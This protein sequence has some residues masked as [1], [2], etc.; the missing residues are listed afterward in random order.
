MKE[1]LVIVPTRERPN[2]I[3]ELIEAYADTTSGNSELLLCLDDDDSGN[4]MIPNVDFVTVMIRPRMRL[5]PWLNYAVNNYE[6]PNPIKY[7]GFMGDDH[8]PRTQDWDSA[9]VEPLRNTLGIAYGNDLLQGEK[10]P[11]AVFM[12][13]QITDTL[14]YF[15]PPEQVHLYLDDYWLALGHRLGSVNYLPDVVIEHEHFT[16]GKVEMDALY[17]DVNSREM[18]DHDFVAFD[19]Y[20][21]GQFDR[22]MA[23][24][25]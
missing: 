25:I 15:C 19:K 18:F 3:V 21:H 17:A 24:F 8:R 13:K 5:G 2:K 1:L 12:N 7:V 11:T 23:A 10:L 6:G 16:T 9:V 22:D 14:G 20:M 4:Y